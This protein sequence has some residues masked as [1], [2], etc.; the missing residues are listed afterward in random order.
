[1][2]KKVLIIGGT[3]FIGYH[4]AKKC[5]NLSWKI[6]S[7]SLNPPRT[8]R[9][10]KKVKYMNFDTS[11]K[12][13]FKYLKK[14]KFD[15]VINL[16]GYVEHKN[17]KKIK[18]GHYKSIKN[19][20]DHFKDKHLKSFIHIGSSTEY[21]KIKV[22]HKESNYC[23][24]VGIYGKYKYKATQFLLKK[25]K[26]NNFPVTIIR[27][28][29][30]YGPNQDT[31]R[32][33]PILIQSCLKKNLFFSSSGQQKRDFLFVDDAVKAIIKSIKSI[34][35]K[36]KIIN[37]G[38]GIPIKL[39]KIMKQ[40]ELET[41]YFDPVYNKIKLRKDEKKIIYPNITNAKKI[42]NW[43]PKISLKRGLRLTIKYYKKHNKV[44]N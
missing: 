34:K 42:I 11:K 21:G 3:G 20:F 15:Y 8:L 17:E 36:G 37:I 4:V 30:L 2:T 23:K 24:P 9:K 29:Q 44:I 32:F 12:N 39:K 19:I 5:I 40:V 14:F 18:N 6:I 27:F 33:I 43:K 7:L 1:M 31:N 28:Y 16:G 35:S 41:G 38:S 13:N 26:N 25:F 22:P 10:L